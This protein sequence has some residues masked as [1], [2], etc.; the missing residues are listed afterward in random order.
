MILIFL[1]R[2]AYKGREERQRA[3]ELNDA[4][5]GLIFAI[6]VVNIFIATFGIDDE[7]T[8]L[9]R[10]QAAGDRSDIEPLTNRG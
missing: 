4:V 8:T 7:K 9:L 10:L 2:F 1:G 3:Q 6:T 5:V